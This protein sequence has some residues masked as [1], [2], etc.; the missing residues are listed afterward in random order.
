M[1]GRRGV[2]GRP[3]PAAGV[4]AAGHVVRDPLFR[5]LMRLYDHDGNR[6][7]APG[8]VL[9]HANDN[10]PTYFPSEGEATAAVQRTCAHYA[11]RGDTPAPTPA[12]F[13]IQSTQQ[14]RTELREPRKARA[15]AA[16]AGAPLPAPDGAEPA[17]E[18]MPD[19]DFSPEE[20]TTP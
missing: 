10:G 13:H 19:L 4:P 5:K 3:D 16:N 9:F 20:L 14:L 18:G 12:D 7:A 1:S 8:G 11:A 17:G 15:R 6:P 2:P